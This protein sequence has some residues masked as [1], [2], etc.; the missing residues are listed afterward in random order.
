MVNANNINVTNCALAAMKFF[1]RYIVA[2][3][4]KNDTNGMCFP[5]PEDACRS[6]HTVRRRRKRKRRKRKKNQK[7]LEKT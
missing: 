3:V 2:I 7:R 4:T 6:F 5:P 1:N